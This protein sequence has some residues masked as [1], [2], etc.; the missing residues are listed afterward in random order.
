MQM[1]MYF[2]VAPKIAPPKP[3]KTT[4]SD[5]VRE[6]L[7][8]CLP[9]DVPSSFAEI[10]SARFEGKRKIIASLVMFDG[11]P[12]EVHLHQWRYGW[13]HGYDYLPGGNISWEGGEWVRYPEDSTN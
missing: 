9:P 5:I 13:S 6:T 10:V 8:A 1:E 7:L 12:A 11:M 4:A 2:D 3:K